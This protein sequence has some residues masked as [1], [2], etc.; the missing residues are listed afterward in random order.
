MRL[1]VFPIEKVHIIGGHHFDPQ[2]F[3]K[4]HERLTD[5]GLLLHPVVVDL[6]E[7]VFFPVD[8]N[9]FQ[10]LLPREVLLIL[11]NKFIDG[12]RNASAETDQSLGM[13]TQHFTVNPG[14]AIIH[15]LEM[16]LGNEL[17]KIVPAGIIFGQ[18]GQ[19]GRSLATHDLLHLLH[20]PRREVHFAAQNRLHVGRMAGLVEANRAIKVA[21]IGHR[22]R[23]HAQFSRPGCHRLGPAGSIESGIFSV[24][25][26][27]N[28]GI[29]HRENHGR[30]SR[31]FE[32]RTETGKRL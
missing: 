3:G 10:S 15:A 29:R 13:L 4:P 6:K 22:D 12:P 31:D 7:E 5:L 2:L 25:M 23:R 30:W 19:V 26:Q 14:F 20:L 32:L 11:Q 27:V 21:M 16:P 28:E 18:E 9:E 8:V 17:L 24:Q 1:V